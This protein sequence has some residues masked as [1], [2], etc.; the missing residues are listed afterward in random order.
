MH[1]RVTKERGAAKFHKCEHCG[2]EAQDWAYDHL[3]MNEK[4]ELAYGVF[5]RDITH[6]IPLCKKCHAKF[7]RKGEKKDRA[8]GY[9][10]A[11]LEVKTHNDL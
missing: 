10:E 9:L 11:M 2:L 4:R 6:Y 8:I 7:D 1:G 3:D 5:S